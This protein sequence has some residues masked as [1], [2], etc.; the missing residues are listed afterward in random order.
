MGLRWWFN[1][2]SL[3]L[4]GLITEVAEKVFAVLMLNGW[5]EFPQEFAVAHCGTARP[6][7]A[8]HV[9]IKLTNINDSSC[10]VPF[11]WMGTNLVVDSH[12]VTDLELRESSGMFCP[13]L[14]CTYICDGCV[15]PLLA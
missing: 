5:D 9:L 8:N 4:L 6:I 14:G 12:M 7:H 1:T 11:Q 13:P 3:S 10:L 2:V 15:K